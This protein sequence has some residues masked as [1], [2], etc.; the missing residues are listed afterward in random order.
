MAE[1]KPPRQRT[2]KVLLSLDFC[3]QKKELGQKAERR[4]EKKHCRLSF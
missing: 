2:F 4:S 3:T 1:R